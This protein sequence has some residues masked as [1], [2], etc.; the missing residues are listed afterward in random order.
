MYYERVFKPREIEKRFRGK[1]EGD[2]E[3]EI[4]AYEN[5]REQ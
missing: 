3:S 2:L 4:K 5:E 1:T